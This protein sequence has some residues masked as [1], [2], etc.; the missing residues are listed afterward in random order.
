MRI[1]Q[2]MAD[3]Q[4]LNPSLQSRTRPLVIPEEPDEIIPDAPPTQ[5]GAPFNIPAKI[6]PSLTTLASA[7]LSKTGQRSENEALSLNEAHKILGEQTLNSLA[8]S[9]SLTGGLHRNLKGYRFQGAAFWEHAVATANLAW[10]LARAVDYPHPVQA[11][12]AGLIHDIGKIILEPW[13]EKSYSQIVELMWKEKLFLWQAEVHVF[14]LDHAA[15]G[16]H[17]CE[18]RRLPTPIGE[19]VRWHHMPEFAT[20]QAELAA[21]VNLA[22]ALAPQETLGLSGLNHKSIHP[23]TLRI[24]SLERSTMEQFRRELLD[25]SQWVWPNQ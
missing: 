3:T 9:L 4:P 13:I 5:A 18:R 8:G 17:L 15:A 6:R 23:P 12:A 21:L 2:T 10:G 20:R 11:Y 25:R 19:A 22:D 7:L 1:N 16:A 24:L 14:G